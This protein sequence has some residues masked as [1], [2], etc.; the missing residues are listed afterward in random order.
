[1]ASHRALSEERDR[2]LIAQV[3][4]PVLALRGFQRVHLEPGQSTLVSF[5][6]GP[7]QLAILDRQMKRTVE[8]GGVDVQIGPSSVETQGE[9]LMVKP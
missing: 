6:V 7:K 1:M 2:Q 3:V 9:Q 8:P 5:D 4:Q